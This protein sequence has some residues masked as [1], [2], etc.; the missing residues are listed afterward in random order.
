MSMQC[1][2]GEGGRRGE[3]REGEDGGAERGGWGVIWY[4]RKLDAI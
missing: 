3:G 2:W 1:E 4:L